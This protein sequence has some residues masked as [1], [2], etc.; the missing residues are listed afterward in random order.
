MFKR[1][2]IIA[3]A[4]TLSACATVYTSEDFSTYQAEHETVAILPY[5]VNIT[6]KELPEG[7]TED[8]INSMEIEESLS[9]QKVLYSQFL[10]RQAKGEYTVEFQDVDKTNTILAR[11]DINADGLMRYTK[12][13]VATLLG[14]DSVISGTITRSKPM[15]TGGAIASTIFFGFGSTNQVHVNMTLHDG[16]TGDLLWSYDH[17]LAGGLGSSPEGVA[18]SLMKEIAKKFPYRRQ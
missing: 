13:E 15:S 3:G 14:V 11:N 4:F 8:D 7:M 2:L 16:A 18:K 12:D 5:T 1:I 6:L 9:F 17:E 10:S